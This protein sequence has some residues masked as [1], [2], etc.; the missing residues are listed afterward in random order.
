MFRSELYRC[1]ANT[2]PFRAFLSILNTLQVE[3][4][5]YGGIDIKLILLRENLI[6]MIQFHTSTQENAFAER[7]KL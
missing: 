5:G 4:G 3:K 6:S 7:E 1:L 2:D